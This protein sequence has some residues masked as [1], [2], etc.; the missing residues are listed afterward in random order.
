MLQ[1]Q[2]VCGIMTP[3]YIFTKNWDKS[4][5]DF[6][7]EKIGINADTLHKLKAAYQFE[8]ANYGAAINQQKN[9]FVLISYGKISIILEL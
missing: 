1:M 4:G 7:C 9:K 5:T 3:I 6:I 8:D 2:K